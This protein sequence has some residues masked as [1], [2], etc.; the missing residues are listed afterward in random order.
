VL[1]KYGFDKPMHCEDV[2]VSARIILDNHRICFCPTARSG[3]LAP[4][5]FGALVTQRLRWFIGWEQCTAKYWFPAF[6]SPLSWRRKLGFTYMFHFRWALL[7]SAFMGA[8]INPIIMSPFLYPLWTWSLEVRWCVYVTLLAYTFV[9]LYSVCSCMWHE[10]ARPY[11]W[12]GVALFFVF[13]W[14]Y[15][16]WHAVLQTVALFRVARGTIGEWTVTKRSADLTD[17]LRMAGLGEPLLNG[18][19]RRAGGV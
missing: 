14:A 6:F 18:S 19:H 3:E 17:G 16:A 9:A 10:R 4:A 12:L 11:S 7:V 15:I 8:C 5:N 1:K 2:D 13:G